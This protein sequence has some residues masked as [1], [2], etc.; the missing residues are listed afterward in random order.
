MSND[1]IKEAIGEYAKAYEKLQLLQEKVP[2]IPEGDQKTGCIGEYYSYRYLSNIHSSLSLE[3]GSHS[4]KGWDIKIV[5][6]GV[7]VQVKTVSAYSKTRTISPI[8]RGWDILHIIYLNKA[9]EPEGFWVIAD[10]NIFGSAESLKSKK[11]KHPDNPNTGS[12]CIPFGENKISE[13]VSA[14]NA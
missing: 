2:S 6:S 13:L 8:H 7:K 3:Y 9:L 12:H 10:N 4:E 14:I 11:C 5:N 1:L